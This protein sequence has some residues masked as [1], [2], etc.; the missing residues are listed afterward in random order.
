MQRR[1]DQRPG[2]TL[3][4]LLVVI[5]I[6]AI[7][8]GLLLPAVQKV[9]A[10]AS[11]TQCANNLKQIGIAVHAFHDSY[12]KLPYNGVQTWA[13]GGDVTTGSWCFQILAFIEQAPLFQ[14]GLVGGNPPEQFLPVKNFLCP[15]R[16]RTGF[17]PNGG[18]GSHQGSNT[19][20]AINCQ[21][22][23]RSGGSTNNADA[24][25]RLTDI[26]DGTANTIFGGEAE[27][28]PNR[29]TDTNSNNWNETWWIGG[30][31]GSGRYATTSQPDAPGVTSTNWGSAHT[32]SASY[33]LC[34][35]SIRSVIYG[36]DLTAAMRPCDGQTTNFGD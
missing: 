30:Y 15:M 36:I 33:L 9:R 28:D 14:K 5:A 11:R 26:L 17:T 7:L 24:N 32:G 34:D 19:D 2:F 13:K 20:Y 4:E 35:G 31:G 12:A 27:M 6:I 18:P 3:I 16:A 1:L 23:N 21:L 25:T 8:I 10:A 29:Y 22:N